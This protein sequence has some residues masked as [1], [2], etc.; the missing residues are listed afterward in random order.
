MDSLITHEAIRDEL[1]RVKPDVVKNT[2]EYRIKNDSYPDDL[3]EIICDALK[4]NEE[5]L[6]L[7]KNHIGYDDQ[8]QLYEL[9]FI[10][11]NANEEYFYIGEE[12]EEVD[13]FCDEPTSSENPPFLISSSSESIDIH[14]SKDEFEEPVVQKKNPTLDNVID[15]DEY[16][17]QQND[18]IEQISRLFSISFDAANLLLKKFDWNIN[19]LFQ[20]AENKSEEIKEWVNK[21]GSL[22]TINIGKGLCCLCYE[23]DVD[24]YRHY[25][26]HAICYE[27]FKSEIETQL[28]E[29]YILLFV[30]LKAV[31]QK[32]CKKTL[33]LF[34]GK[35]RVK[36]IKENTSSIKCSLIKN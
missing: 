18:M 28:K 4:G 5:L 21:Q 35:Q 23:E 13:D 32:S 29:C 7:F 14:K 26:G 1:F 19:L 12:E 3:F 11:Q 27:C 24:L 25:C 22:K 15:I 20:K 30:E 31:V 9:I 16:Q 17:K 8:N 10:P 36:I 33:K 34:V 2:E 6:E